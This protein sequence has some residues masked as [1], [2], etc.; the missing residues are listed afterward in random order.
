MSTN[1]NVGLNGK[2]VGVPVK[3]MHESEGHVVTVRNREEEE[4]LLRLSILLSRNV[5]LSSF[6][7]VRSLFLMRER[8]LETI[9]EK[10]ICI[11]DAMKRGALNTNNKERWSLFSKKRTK[12]VALFFFRVLLSSLGVSSASRDERL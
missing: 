5:F 2:G 10:S 3:L 11:N 4:S 8:E 1:N 12:V 9:W 6:F 7:F